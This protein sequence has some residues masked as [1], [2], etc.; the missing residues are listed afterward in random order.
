M[1]PQ[2]SPDAL[3]AT[4]SALALPISPSPLSDESA[5]LSTAFTLLEEVDH[6]RAFVYTP[7]TPPTAL[8]DLLI[9]RGL[10]PPFDRA[11][12]L[13]FLAAE[14]QAARLASHAADARRPRGTADDRFT[15]ALSRAVRALDINADNVVSAAD[16]AA[17]IDAVCA[18]VADRDLGKAVCRVEGNLDAARDVCTKLGEEHAIRRALV[19]RRLGVTVYG[20][21]CSEK[22]AGG[23]DAVERAL[24]TE[25]EDAVRTITVFHAL[26]ARD[27]VLETG[28]VS[29]GGGGGGVKE[30]LMGTVPDRGGRV[31]AAAKSKANMPTFRERRAGGGQGRGRGGGRS[32]RGRRRGR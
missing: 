24:R 12:V 18:A 22:A 27:W 23:F 6:T 5:Y 31:G 15:T 4:L 14:A 13:D 21:G 28:R 11:A 20:F 29:G 16:V 10:A 2:P 8:P 32:G 3:L 19:L 30:V 26:T 9:Q 25:V 7:S 1:L 17:V